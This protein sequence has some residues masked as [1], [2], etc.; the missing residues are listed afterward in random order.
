MSVSCGPFSTVVVLRLVV[1]SLLPFDPVRFKDGNETFQ[2][3][4][5]D[6]EGT[7]QF[8]AYFTGRRF[9]HFGRGS[10]GVAFKCP[11]DVWHGYLVWMSR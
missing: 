3:M 5:M 10:D 4:A 6:M 2:A 7:C 9:D 11:Y 1:L 8:Q